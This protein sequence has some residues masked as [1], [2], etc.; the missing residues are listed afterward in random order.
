MAGWY[1]VASPLDEVLDAFRA[2]LDER[3]SVSGGPEKDRG[4]FRC[5]NCRGCSHCRFCNGCSDCEDCTYCDECSEC[6]GCTHCNG[7]D[8][9]TQTTHSAWSSACKDASYVTLCLDCTG[10]VQCFACVGLRNEEFCI[11]NEKLPRK[12]YF[13]RVAALRGA[14]EERI[15]AGWRPPWSRDH[16]PE[17]EAEAEDADE[18]YE[19]EVY[20]DEVYE[21]EQPEAA[22]VVEDPGPADSSVSLH[23]EALWSSEMPADTPTPLVEARED[24]GPLPAGPTR[25]EPTVDTGEP[26]ESPSRRRDDRWGYDER[27]RSHAAAARDE[28]TQSTRIPEPPPFGGPGDEREE[29]HGSVP[30]GR[31][32]GE[33]PTR[34]RDQANFDRYGWSAQAGGTSEHSW[35]GRSAEPERWPSPNDPEPPT[36]T[37]RRVDPDRSPQFGRSRRPWN[38]DV[39]LE[40]P[41]PRWTPEDRERETRPSKPRSEVGG[42]PRPSWSPPEEPERDTRPR[43]ETGRR[44]AT[45]ETSEFRAIESDESV[46]RNRWTAE[47][48]SSRWLPESPLSE[49]ERRRL[50]S[51]TSLRR[52]RRETAASPS[53]R[54]VAIEPSRTV[55]DVEPPVP[56]A[57]DSDLLAQELDAWSPYEDA[58]RSR[59]GPDDQTE[60]DAPV[61]RGQARAEISGAARASSGPIEERRSSSRPV[62]VSLGAGR[63]PER[64]RPPEPRERGGL[65]RGRAPARPTPAGR[66]S[67]APS[68]RRAKRPSRARDDTTSKYRAA[69][70]GG[71]DG[72]DPGTS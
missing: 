4:N 18:A 25:T 45:A 38:P 68:L 72:E 58:R 55:T 50:E 36:R 40:Q 41:L 62:K 22:V 12:T 21:D 71:S 23:L 9:C 63:R 28:D 69:M 33:E 59:L 1:P 46:R 31:L 48:R 61:R 34:R 54:P 52:R 60:P 30:R 37:R 56:P 51:D 32:D 13:S 3:A 7:C 47:Q 70:G 8:R 2:L 67:D 35:P 16:E 39:D 42:L 14:F 53:A 15:A 11:L 10:C 65:S 5:E 64:P 20:E 19:D 49:P 27:R 66:Q 17:A 24:S 44:W 29:R 6:S 43:P 26:V 57:R